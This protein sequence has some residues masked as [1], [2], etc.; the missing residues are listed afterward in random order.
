MTCTEQQ[1]RAALD[2]MVERLREV[3]GRTIGGKVCVPVARFSERD[4]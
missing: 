3:P 2:A 4:E 1:L